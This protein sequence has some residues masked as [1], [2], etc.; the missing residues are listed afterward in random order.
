MKVELGRKQRENAINISD[1]ISNHTKYQLFKY[2]PMKSLRLVDP[3]HETYFKL[4]SMNKLKEKGQK[5]FHLNSTL[6]E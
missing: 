5:I 1:L 6:P 4:K 2:I 3:I